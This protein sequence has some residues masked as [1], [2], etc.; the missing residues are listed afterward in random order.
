MSLNRTGRSGWRF[1]SP[2]SD[3]AQETRGGG[4]EGR[5]MCLLWSLLRPVLSS[6]PARPCSSAQLPESALRWPWALMRESSWEREVLPHHLPVRGCGLPGGRRRSSGSRK[7]RGGGRMT[8]SQS[9]FCFRIRFACFELYINGV[10]Y[11]FMS[12]NLAFVFFESF[13]SVFSILGNHFSI[14]FIT[15]FFFIPMRWVSDLIQYTFHFHYSI[16]CFFFLRILGLFWWSLVS[17]IKL[18]ETFQNVIIVWYTFIVTVSHSHNPAILQCFGVWFCGLFLQISPSCG[19]FPF[20][21][22]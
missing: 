21:V 16:C 8:G 1:Q 4:R 20:F 5:R 7:E 14:L 2:I 12:L 22:T 11:H 6:S 19:S 10:Q 3:A 15:D 17:S 18:E 9:F 13:L